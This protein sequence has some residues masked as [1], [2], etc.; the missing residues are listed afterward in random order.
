M[1]TYKV[2]T[3]NHKQYMSL[4]RENY[5]IKVCLK[6]KK[7]TQSFYDINLH[8]SKLKYFYCKKKSY[9][10]IIFTFVTKYHLKNIFKWK[11]KLSNRVRRKLLREN[12]SSK[13]NASLI[14]IRDTYKK[15]PHYPSVL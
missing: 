7:Q 11:K 9:M 13:S 15:T 8:T 4:I 3:H 2:R 14:N 1:I 6:W 10:L 12:S 5:S